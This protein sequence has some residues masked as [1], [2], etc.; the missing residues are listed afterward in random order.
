MH[1]HTQ[2]LPGIHTYLCKNACSNE[3]TH[4]L[5]K[6]FALALT[7]HLNF[8]VPQAVFASNWESTDQ[9]VS[10]RFGGLENCV[11]LPCQFTD[12]YN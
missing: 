9:Q 7:A 1:M 2:Q 12:L 5:Q 4:T 6:A 10:T 8:P 11:L 3:R